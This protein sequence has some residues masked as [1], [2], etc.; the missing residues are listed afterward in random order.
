MDWILLMPIV[1]F[2]SKD[3]KTELMEE[4]EQRLQSYFPSIKLVDLL[5][6]QAENAV[7]ALLWKAPLFRVNELKNLKVLISLGQGVDHL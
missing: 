7:T 1:A 5:S 6:N 2:Y 4:W 3:S